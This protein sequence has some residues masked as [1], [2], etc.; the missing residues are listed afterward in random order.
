MIMTGFVADA[1]PFRAEQTA[2][3][4]HLLG[5]VVEHT[6]PAVLGEGVEAGWAEAV[7]DPALIDWPARQGAAL[8]PFDVVAGRPVSPCLGAPV[9]RGRGGLGRWGENPMADALVTA[10][11]K[12]CRW[13]L[14]VERADGLGWAVPGGSVDPGEAPLE[15]AARELAEETGL[16]IDPGLWVAGEPRHVPDPRGSDEAWAVTVAATA[17]LGPVE[18][19]PPVTGAD[20]AARAVWVWADT[21]H[22]LTRTLG[23]VFDGT[24]FA[25]HTGL[26]REHLD[27]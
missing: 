6:D 15:A 25:A 21:Y 16:V 18:D 23:A 1:D 13:V 24:V 22:V 11:R 26:L 20:D 19:L 8:I 7:T 17:D 4:R 3:L 27:A 2:R 14:M 12:G 10:L 5:P 9:A